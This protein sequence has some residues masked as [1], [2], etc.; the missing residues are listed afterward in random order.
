MESKL[1]GYFSKKRKENIRVLSSHNVLEIC[2]ACLCS[3]VVP[4]NWVEHWKHNDYFLFNSPI[5]AYS[6]IQ[7]LEDCHEYVLYAYKQYQFRVENGSVFDE[8][9]E[10]ENVEDLSSE[11]VLLGYDAV[12]RNYSKQ[13]GCSPLFCNLGAEKMKTN[14]YCLFS[15]FN[16]ALE[17]AVIFSRGHGE[18]G[19]YYVVEV[20]RADYQDILGI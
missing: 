11:F 3:F 7:D 8:E 1:I 17:G 9:V 20:Y 13:F 19:P 2:N 16:E 15:S 10:S 14:K 12:N 4:D 18:P 6:I 5:I